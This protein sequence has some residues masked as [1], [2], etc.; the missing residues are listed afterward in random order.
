MSPT[1]RA[2]LHTRYPIASILIY[3]GTLVLHYT[4]GAVGIYL[5]YDSWIAYLLGSVY[6][7]FALGEMYVLMPIQVCPNCVYHGLEN[8]MCISAMNIVSRK[9][10]KPGKVENF[11]ERAQGILCPNN[12]YM[13]SL[14]I[15]ILAMIPA[16]ILQFSFWV[17]GILLA[18]TALLVFRFFV[19][20]PK[21]AC[22]HCRA[23]QVCP[24]AAAMGVRDE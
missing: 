7:T 1:T 13:A 18:V 5:G 8:S 12:L 11:P 21:V 20:F 22:L 6:L 9:I 23:K 16:L 3:N 14:F 19:V 4:L 15:P 17:L 24:Q 2:E 10:A